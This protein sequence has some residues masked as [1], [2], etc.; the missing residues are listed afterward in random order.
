MKLA[1]K[2]ISSSGL[3]NCKLSSAAWLALDFLAFFLP[4][5]FLFFLDERLPDA[6]F[7]DSESSDDVAL[8]DLV[9]NRK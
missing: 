4:D 3:M 8:T 1:L 9:T 7:V 6:L 2:N 5:N